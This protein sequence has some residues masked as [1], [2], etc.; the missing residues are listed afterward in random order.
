MPFQAFKN[1]G[2]HTYHPGWSWDG[3]C[4][5]AALYVIRE[6][7]LFMQGKG[8][9]EI[10]QKNDVVFLP[11]TDNRMF[12]NRGDTKVG[13]YFVSFWYDVRCDLGIR[14]LLRGTDCR[15]LFEDVV[16]AYLS[17]TPGSR[18]QVAET[19]F[20]LLHTLTRL[21]LPPSERLPASVEQAVTFVRENYHKRIT[22]QDLCAASGYSSAHLRRLFLQNFGMPP[23]QYVRDKRIAIAREMLS[24]SPEMN[25]EE[26]ADAVGLCSASHFC[27]IFKE[28]T[29]T[30]PRAYRQKAKNTPPV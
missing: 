6:G 4:T 10:L 11:P 26:I 1:A 18:L 28:Y 16:A 12:A 17:D 21:S 22:E 25:V 13:V 8:T 7:E 5:Y 15:P 20:R 27:K 30:T 9:A 19:F 2:Y 3:K 23:M 29:G 14:T 24:N